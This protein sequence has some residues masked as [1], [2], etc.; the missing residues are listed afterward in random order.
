MTGPL[1]AVG[2]PITREYGM[3][4]RI[5]TIRIVDLALRVSPE[6]RLPRRCTSPRM[7]PS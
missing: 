4:G 7:E 1:R 3:H 5:G 6:I 2:H